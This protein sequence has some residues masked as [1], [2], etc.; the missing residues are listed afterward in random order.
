MGNKMGNNTL[1]CLGEEQPSYDI[2][3]LFKWICDK[4]DKNLDI[5]GSFELKQDLSGKKLSFEIL[6]LSSNYYNRFIYTLVDK[7]E[8]GSF[9]DYLFFDDENYPNEDSIPIAV[10]EVT[11]NSG[12]EAGNMV[13]Q[14]SPKKIPIIEKWGDLPYC[15]MISN[16]CK[17]EDTIKSFSQVHN[18][19]FATIKSIGKKNDI[20]IT[21]TNN[22]GYSLYNTPFN[23]NSI[24]DI[25][26]QENLKKLGRGVP[27]R[28]KHDNNEI[29]ITCNLYKENGN[30]DPGEGYVASRSYLVRSLNDNIKI[31]IKSH[32]RGYDFF[33][34]NGKLIKVLK[35]VGTTILFEDNKFI[36]FNK[37]DKIFE[38][39]RTY[40]KYSNSGEKIATILMENYFKSNGWSVLF[41]NHAGCAKTDVLI[42]ENSYQTEKGKGIPDIVFYKKE[43]NELLVIEGETSKNYKKGI[44]QSKEKEFDNFIS[45]EFLSRLPKDI[46]TKKYL[47]TY[48]N[49]NNEDYVIFNLT[50]D[51]EINFNENA[52]PIE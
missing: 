47:C 48:G 7:N 25:I 3:N 13:D 19:G 32:N 22:Y 10:A 38:G 16:S 14:R 41:T 9:V 1:W 31:K 35:K 8:K 30:H 6:G 26:K 50:N 2:V 36:D 37:N 24:D 33:N 40:W 11:K 52:T 21:Q 44:I 49:Y 23:Y 15:Y 42:D 34:G 28:V 4:F 51:F 46:S 45:R 18:C 27:S 12:D 39:V 5:V 29:L 43:T 20:V 17:T